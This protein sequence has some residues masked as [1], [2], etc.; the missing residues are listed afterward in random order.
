MTNKLREMLKT[1]TTDVD[2][3]RKSCLSYLPEVLQYISKSSIVTD[4]KYPLI[5]SPQNPKV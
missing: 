5:K 1:G 4:I 3:E 2:L